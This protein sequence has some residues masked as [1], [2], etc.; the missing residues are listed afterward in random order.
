[1]VAKYLAPLGVAAALLVAPT[2]GAAQ[3]VDYVAQVEALGGDAKKGKKVYRKCKAC[4]ELAK[5]KNKV[6]P[7]Q[8][9]II[10]RPAGII[11]DFGYSDA[12]KDSGLVW[13]VETLTAWLSTK[14]KSYMEGTK[15]NFAGLKK[16]N[17]VKNV[18][19]YMAEEGGI[20][21]AGTN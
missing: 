14:S 21:D 20:Y 7:H 15:M 10:G 1:M 16:E 17:D 8:V 2:I 5:E 3:D 18:I 11:A 4:H 6:G 19:A 13:D 12:M 9:G